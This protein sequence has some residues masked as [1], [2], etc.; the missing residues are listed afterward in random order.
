MKKAYEAPTI[1]KIFYETEAFAAG[2]ILSGVDTGTGD[3]GNW[4]EFV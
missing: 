1:E 4:G 3:E 2:N